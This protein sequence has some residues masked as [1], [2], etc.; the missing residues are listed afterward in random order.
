MTDLPMIVLINNFSA[1]AAEIVSGALRDY[2]RAWLIGERSFGKGSVQN[3]LG[4]VN[5][6]LRLKMTTAHYYL[7]SGQCIH[8]K[9]DSKNWGVDPDLKI[10]LTPNEI[11]DVIDIQRDAEIV[12]HVNGSKVTST[13]SKQT[14]SPAVAS[15]DDEEEKSPTTRKYPPEDIQL[16]AAIAVMQ[17]RL[18]FD[19]PWETIKGTTGTTEKIL[20]EIKK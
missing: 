15:D 14:T 9:P 12:N 7:P 4:L 5:D 8:K 17:A 3:V 18:M 20:V 10:E 6:T 2:H 13:T 11:R 16:Q 1:S 19:L